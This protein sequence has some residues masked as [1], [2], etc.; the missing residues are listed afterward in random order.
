M[1]GPLVTMIN[2]G[3]AVLIFR[4]LIDVLKAEYLD[5]LQGMATL[6]SFNASR[7]RGLELKKGA[8]EVRDAAIRLVMLELALR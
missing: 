5:S 4:V 1:F 2:L 3:Q 7:Q 8:F 6:K